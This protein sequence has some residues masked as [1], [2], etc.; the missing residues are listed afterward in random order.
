MLRS[1][2]FWL[3]AVPSLLRRR[4]RFVRQAGRSDCGVAAA[5]T[6]L[7]LMGRRGD[8]VAATDRLDPDRK[9]AS[10]EALRL[11]FAEDQGLEAEAL[12]VPA[13]SLGKVRGRVILHMTQQHYVVLLNRSRHGVLVFDPAM[14]PVFYPAADFAALY[15][16]TLLAVRRSRASPGVPATES[17]AAA[18]EPRA[19]GWQARALFVLGLASRCLE[20]GALLCIVATLYLVLNRASASAIVSVFSIL[21]L[22]G[23]LLLA[24]RRLR[25][26]SEEDWVRGRQ[27]SVWRGLVKTALKG[28]DLSGFRG[29]SERDVSGQLR[30]G[31][32]G[33]LP[34]RALLPASLGSVVAMAG[35]LC[36]LSPWVALAHLGLYAGL[37]VIVTLDDV[38]VCRR[39]VRKTTGRYSRLVPGYGLFNPTAAPD[40]VGEAAKWGVIGTAG[41]MVIWASL[42]PVALMFWILTAMQIVPIDFRK[43]PQIAP[44]LA[45]NE[46]VPVL[47][48]AEVPLRRQKV[49]GEVAVKVSRKDG[50]MAIDG[51]GPLTAML[52]Q[53]DLTVREQRHI[54]AEIVARAL[55]ALP[56]PDRPEAGPVR[57][58]GPGQEASQADFEQLMIARDATRNPGDPQLPAKPQEA[59]ADGVNDPVLRDLFSCDAR[60]LPVFWDVRGQMRLPELQARLARSG[61]KRAGHL[62]MR[63]LTLVEAA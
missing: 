58:F 21:A 23:L 54:M 16:G 8:P 26:A 15:S 36:L 49:V 14:G 55:D 30:R 31:M 29:R 41:M 56:E 17:R 10:L 45:G 60:D 43:L 61:V 2:L 51:I 20:A 33:V 28:A 9:G 3:R 11:F 27:R 24:V 38:K 52:E 4:S 6:V 32:T 46:S 53:P 1:S 35:L 39:S 22:C 25:A 18:G 5:L 13:G 34:P 63:R 44:A 19:R 37:L 62:T 48:A 47:T 50:Q 42:P 40:L 57:I 12:K 7:R 59:L